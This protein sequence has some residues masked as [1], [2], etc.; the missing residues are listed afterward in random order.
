MIPLPTESPDLIE[1]IAL[2]GSFLFGL[3][4]VAEAAW[5][6]ILQDTWLGS[7]CSS[8]MWVVLAAFVWRT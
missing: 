3:Y 7:A 2:A 6:M 4:L 1:A 8:A 5:M